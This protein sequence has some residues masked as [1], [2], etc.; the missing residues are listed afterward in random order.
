MPYLNLTCKRCGYQWSSHNGNPKRCP[1]CGTHHWDTEPWVFTCKRCGNTWVAKGNSI[2]KRC[3]AC[4]SREW[5]KE[6]DELRAN[7]GGRRQYQVSDELYQSIID[8]Y[9][10]GMSCVDIAI[11]FDI[12]YSKVYSAVRNAMPN[13]E[14]KI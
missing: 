12:P 2:P 3:P 5:D 14:I 6:E 4:S 8:S 7:G 13:R 10:K 11:A 1:Q 9:R